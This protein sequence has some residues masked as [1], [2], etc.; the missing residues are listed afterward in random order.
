MPSLGCR[1]TLVCV[2]V[3]V[4]VCVVGAFGEGGGK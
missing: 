4:P 1:F 2:Y 3:C